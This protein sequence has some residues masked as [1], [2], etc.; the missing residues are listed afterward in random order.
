MLGILGWYGD[1]LSVRTP[2]PECDSSSRRVEGQRQGLYYF[3]E[4]FPS[5]DVNLLL[6]VLPMS[7][8]TCVYV[9]SHVYARVCGRV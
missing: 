5:S 8:N 2:V 1:D 6:G 3:F 7:P 4:D 9:N